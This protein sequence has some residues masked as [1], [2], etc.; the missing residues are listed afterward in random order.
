M[1]FIWFGNKYK[2]TNNCIYNVIQEEKKSNTLQI[3]MYLI[4]MLISKDS[5]VSFVQIQTS[6]L[7]VINSLRSNLPGRCKK[8]KKKKK[9][10]GGS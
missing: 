9:K 5:E 1:C 7:N 3:Y 10:G 2:Q 6:K 4:C 8:K